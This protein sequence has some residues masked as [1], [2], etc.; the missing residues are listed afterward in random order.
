MNIA[1]TSP[2]YEYWNSEQDEND[3]NERLRDRVLNKFLCSFATKLG[4]ERGV[5]NDLW[6]AT[7]NHLCGWCWYKN[8]CP[9]W[10]KEYQYRIK[11]WKLATTNRIT[12]TGSIE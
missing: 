3:E 9:I 8:I 5:K 2:L 12:N 1:Q 7:P 11:C 4:C 10:I 6:K